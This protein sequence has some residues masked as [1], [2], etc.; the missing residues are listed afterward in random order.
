MLEPRSALLLRGDLAVCSGLS[1]ARALI[2]SNFDL[3]LD[4]E[5]I[6]A[7]AHYSRSHFIR[8]FRKTYAQT[9]HQYLVERRI[10]KAKELLVASEL[11][12]T[13]ICLA[14]GFESLGSFSALFHRYVGRAPQHY[15]RHFVAVRKFPHRFIPACYLLMA[16]IKPLV[17]Q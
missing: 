13:D 17:A 15:R 3:P 16:G 10:E 6:A 1:R 4:L 7:S 9:P 5:R 14:V 2:D 8:L 12:V 11:S